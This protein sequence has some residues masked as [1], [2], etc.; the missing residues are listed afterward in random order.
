[1][2]NLETFDQHG[3]SKPILD[4]PR[5]LEA[6]R[7]QGIQPHELI[8][9]EL[10]QMKEIYKDGMNDKKSLQIKL[11]HYEMRRKNKL[12]L[13]REERRALI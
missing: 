4:S 10:H 2:I 13:L 11:E 1:M 6:C 8:I 7:R 3:R 12:K 9:K 5:S